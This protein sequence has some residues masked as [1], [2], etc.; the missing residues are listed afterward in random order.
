MLIDT[1]NS[2]IVVIENASELPYSGGPKGELNAAYFNY[3]KDINIGINLGDVMKIQ[4]RTWF[5]DIFSPALLVK[6]FQCVGENLN[7]A[8]I[9][10]VGAIWFILTTLIMDTPLV[11]V[12]GLFVWLLLWVAAFIL[13][14]FFTKNSPMGVFLELAPTWLTL[15]TMFR[16]YLGSLLERTYK[17]EGV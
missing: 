8:G 13:G 4:D 3:A 10:G 1:C 12:M 7:A 11:V 9:K 2:A 14:I 6:E 15:W 5:N 17:L 16:W